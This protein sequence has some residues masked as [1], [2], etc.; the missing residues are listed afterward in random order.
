MTQVDFDALIRTIE[1]D[2]VIRLF[3]E[4]HRDIRELPYRL[5]MTLQHLQLLPPDEQDLVMRQALQHV[6][7]AERLAAWEGHEA[8]SPA[9]TT[10]LVAYLLSGFSG[11]A[12]AQTAERIM[13]K[14]AG[15]LTEMTADSIS[16]STGAS[17]SPTSGANTASTCCDR[18]SWSGENSSSCSAGS[19]GCPALPCA[20]RKGAS[21]TKA[22][23]RYGQ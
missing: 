23:A 16:V 5:G 8:Y 6:F 2:R 17:S 9:H 11:E 14:N 21:L 15:T 12:V 10:L 13:A 3:G 4:E 19:A 7:G 1:A 18:A 20:W 22:P